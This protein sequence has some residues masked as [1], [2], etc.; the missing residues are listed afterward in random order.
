[1]R[2]DQYFNEQ[3]EGGELIKP[4]VSEER[5]NM[6]IIATVTG[7]CSRIIQ[8]DKAVTYRHL[9]DDK[10]MCHYLRLQQTKPMAS[11]HRRVSP[12]GRLCKALW[13]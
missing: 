11:L 7:Q 8:G 6:V 4:R 10:M 9:L 5:N 2:K 3:P 13:R 12:F 1:M